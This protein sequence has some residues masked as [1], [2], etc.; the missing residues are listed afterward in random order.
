LLIK[1]FGVGPERYFDTIADR[2]DSILILSALILEVIPKDLYAH[3][4]DVLL[5][6]ARIY[7]ILQLI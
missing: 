1:I 4:F 3:N 5:K 7:K 6:M 2:V